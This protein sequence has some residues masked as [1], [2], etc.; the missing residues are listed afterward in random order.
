M[1]I[2]NSKILQYKFLNE[3]YEDAYYPPHLVDEIKNIFVDLCEKIESNQPENL[4]GLYLLTHAAT[5]KIND[6]KDAFEEA[7]KVAGRIQ[8]EKIKTIVIDTDQSFI[9]L[10]LAEKLAVRMEADRYQIEELQANSLMTA[11]AL[12]L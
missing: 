12:S 10:N 9:K 4:D 11:V 7:M 5:E 1:P 2:Q 6:L 3:M 8:A